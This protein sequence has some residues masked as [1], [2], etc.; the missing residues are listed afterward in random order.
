MAPP[1]TVARAAVIEEKRRPASPPPTRLLPR[2]LPRLPPRLDEGEVGGPEDQ[3]LL[4]S[5]AVESLGEKRPAVRLKAQ[6]NLL[7]LLRGAQ[8]ADMGARLAQLYGE[9]VREQLARLLPCPA[10]AKEGRL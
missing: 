9:G 6:A 8:A 10:S 4:L 5:E 7:A 1:T 3:S 2:L